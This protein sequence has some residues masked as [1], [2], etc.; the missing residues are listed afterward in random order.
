MTPTRD[1][2]TAGGVAL[3]AGFLLAAAVLYRNPVD[4]LAAATATASA[5][6]YFLALPT[7]GLLAGV[8]V[9]AGGR[10]AVPLLIAFGT[11]LG[12]FGVGLAVWS[13]LTADAPLVLS[14]VGATVTALSVVALVAGTLRLVGSLGVIVDTAWGA[15]GPPDR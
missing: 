10:Y 6:V 13:L 4:G 2:E 5:A 14:A 9:V 15:R 11:Y 8:Y 1:R 7:A 3:A 12:V